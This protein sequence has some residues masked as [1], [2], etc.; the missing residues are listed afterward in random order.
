MD[1][2]PTVWSTPSA[3]LVLPCGSRSMTRVRR[4]NSASA[5]PRFT[6]DVV[7][8]TPPFWLAIVMTRIRPGTGKGSCSAACSTRV[9]R[10][11]SMAM[12]L[13]KS[14]MPTP[15]GPPDAWSAARLLRSRSPGSIIAGPSLVTRMPVSRGTDAGGCTCS[16]WNRELSRSGMRRRREPSPCSPCHDH[17]G[18]GSLPEGRTDSPRVHVPHPRGLEF[19][20]QCGQLLQRLRAHQGHQ[21][22]T[23]PHEPPAPADQAGERCDRAGGDHVDG[24]HSA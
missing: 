19:G 20:D 8:P 12:G 15:E 22:G 9:A 16:T 10:I 11:A 17:H 3:V 2:V 18:S 24:P 7:L 21:L 14:A 6:V 4:P 1:G 5:T 23:R 13:S